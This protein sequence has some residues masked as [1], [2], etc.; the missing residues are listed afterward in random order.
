MR[1]ERIDIMSIQL[2]TKMKLLAPAHDIFEAFVDPMKIKNF[3]FSSSSQ[4]WES[5]KI[6]SLSYVEYNAPPFE[7][8][9]VECEAGKRIVFIWGEDE[10]NKRT[11]TISL[12]PIDDALTLIEVKESGFVEMEGL[13]ELLIN[14]KEGWVFMLTCLKAYLENGIDSLKLGLFIE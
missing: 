2:V 1:Y 7:I 14:S 13:T 12:S 9:I 11:V 8:K 6:V 3:W 4:R 10:I 5:G